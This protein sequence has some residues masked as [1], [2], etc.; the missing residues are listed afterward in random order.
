MRQLRLALIAIIGGGLFWGC[1]IIPVPLAGHTGRYKGIDE[2]TVKFI[3]IGS[4]TREDVL[5]RLGA[6]D[7]ASEEGFEYGTEKFSWGLLWIVFIP[8]PAGAP[9]TP[10]GGFLWGKVRPLI[11]EFDENS[12]VKAVRF[13]EGY[14]SSVSADKQQTPAALKV[15]VKSA[16]LADVEAKLFGESG[17]VRGPQRFEAEF[18]R[19][20]L[21]VPDTWRLRTFI[22][23]AMACP[24]GSEVKF[25]GTIDGAK[26]EAKM[27]KD[28]ASF[29]R[30]KFKG[31]KFSDEQQMKEFVDPFIKK[32]GLIE[33][34]LDGFAAGRPVQVNV[35]I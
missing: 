4:T 11:I 33:F 5:L 1:V 10:G 23:E 14:T 18:E 22:K 2:E 30:V 8:N 35:R 3:Q 25:E 26:F 24:P 21:A 28:K 34:K 29:M 27:E 16:T 13:G 12:I 17:L 15:T 19:M 20:V 9:G 32:Q 31:L 6:P 7:Q